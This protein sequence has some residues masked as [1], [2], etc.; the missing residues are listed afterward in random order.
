ME[1]QLGHPLTTLNDVY[2]ATGEDKYLQGAARLVDQALAGDVPIRLEEKDREEG[3]FLGPR[4]REHPITVPHLER[5]EQEKF[6]DL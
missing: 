1:R 5:P 4:D 2:E 6:H 3:A